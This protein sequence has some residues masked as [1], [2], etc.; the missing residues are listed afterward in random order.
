MCLPLILF[1][2]THLMRPGAGIMMVLVHTV[3]RGF[4][5]APSKVHY[6]SADPI[7]ANFTFSPV[8]SLVCE[9]RFL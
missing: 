8:V 5:P 6:A 1:F 9:L 2:P 3:S 4:H 7:S